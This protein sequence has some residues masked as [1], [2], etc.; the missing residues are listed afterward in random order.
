MLLFEG[1]AT[2]MEGIGAQHVMIKQMTQHLTCRQAVR[3]A[4]H[5]A[6]QQGV[7]VRTMCGLSQRLHFPPT[8]HHFSRRKY[9]DDS[10][11]GD[12]LFHEF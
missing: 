1:C 9:V 8:K 3:S 11:D 4:M 10:V 12:N 6:T 7:G 2:V 5:S